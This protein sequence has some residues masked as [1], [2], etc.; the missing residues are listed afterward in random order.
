M[1]TGADGN[2][3][4]PGREGGIE[5]VGSASGIGAR[6]DR[7]AWAALSQPAQGAWSWSRAIV[8]IIAA[9]ACAVI[10]YLTVYPEP[11]FIV[12][13][14]VVYAVLVFRARTIPVRYRGPAGP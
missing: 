6:L 5:L 14:S 8:T 10:I 9:M 12:A 13:L 3:N 11:A 2:G 7:G 4:T 1:A